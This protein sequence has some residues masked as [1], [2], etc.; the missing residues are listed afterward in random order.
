[1]VH[2][3]NIKINLIINLSVDNGLPGSSLLGDICRKTLAKI[4]KSM[5]R[6]VLS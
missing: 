6:I 2:G 1:M 4:K 3:G 5:R